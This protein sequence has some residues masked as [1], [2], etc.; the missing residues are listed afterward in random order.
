MKHP[1]HPVLGHSDCTTCT[2]QSGCA[3]YINYELLARSLTAEGACMRKYVLGAQ[4][5]SQLVLAIPYPYR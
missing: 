2:E 5:G 3:F 4:E 1:L